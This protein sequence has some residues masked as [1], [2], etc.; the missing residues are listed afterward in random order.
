MIKATKHLGL[1]K[2]AYDEADLSIQCVID[3]LVA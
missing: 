2:S 3:L 1:A